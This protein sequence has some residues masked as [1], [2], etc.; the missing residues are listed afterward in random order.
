MNKCVVRKM[1]D[2]IAEDARPIIAKI[3]KIL[4]TIVVV[5]MFVLAGLGISIGIAMWLFPDNSAAQGFVSCSIAI[6]IFA[7]GPL[8]AIYFIDK[9]K[10]A[11]EACK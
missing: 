7:I 9:Y 10:S 5:T 1:K 2:D 3:R 6:F 4:P 11:V 8:T